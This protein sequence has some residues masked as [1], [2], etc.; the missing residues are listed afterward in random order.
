MAP[1]PKSAQLHS[2]G[3]V[4]HKLVGPALRASELGLVRL[5]ILNYS[6]PEKLMLLEDLVLE[7]CG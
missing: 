6:V 7:Y 3:V 1:K 5:Q 4:R 2:M